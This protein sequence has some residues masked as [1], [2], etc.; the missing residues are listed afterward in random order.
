[1]EP[2]ISS[3]EG[4]STPGS[5]F[6]LACAVVA[7]KAFIPPPGATCADETGLDAAT[8]PGDPSTGAGVSP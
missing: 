8:I 1:M 3:S 6:N 4:L 5:A 2:S 7:H